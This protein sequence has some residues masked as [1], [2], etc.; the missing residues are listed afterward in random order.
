VTQIHP[1]YRPTGTGPQ[2]IYSIAS[3][4]GEAEKREKTTSEGRG[5]VH[6][7]ATGSTG[8]GRGASACG[9]LAGAVGGT[10]A[11]SGWAAVAAGSRGRV[12]GIGGVLGGQV[13]ALVVTGLVALELGSS[14]GAGGGNALVVPV[15][16]HETGNGLLVGV[17]LVA[18]IGTV[19]AVARKL[20]RL[21]RTC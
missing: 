11:G 4:Q 13:T 18:H 16:A 14:I 6:S 10:A 8:R 9:S 15:A 20:K 7:N 12:T 19:S 5:A 21:L 3:L 2:S 17:H 1:H